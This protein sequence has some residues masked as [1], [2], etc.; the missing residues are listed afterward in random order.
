MSK[1]AVCKNKEFLWTPDLAYAIGLLTT[2]G[3]LSKDGRHISLVSA[4]IELLKKFQKCLPFKTNISKNAPGGYSVNSIYRVQF[5]NVAF[6]N[7]LLKIGL[8][9]N[10]TFT[11]KELDIP[12]IFFKDYLRGHLDGDGDIVTYTDK[13]NVYKNKRYT[14]QRIYTRFRSASEKHMTWLC[15]KIK[16]NLSA[17]SNIYKQIDKRNGHCTMWQIRF[18]KKDSINLLT[19]IYYSKNIPS[20]DRKRLKFE[21]F[22]CSNTEN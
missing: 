20:L 19:K 2:D 18:A 8:F 11:I 4:D 21:K 13:Y 5:S 3:S 6:Y 9:P 22:I 7:W 14:Y 10:K 17:S 1:I 12:D 15:N 16:I